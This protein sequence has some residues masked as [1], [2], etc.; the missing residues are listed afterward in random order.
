RLIEPPFAAAEPVAPNR[1]LF[2]F[3]T[4]LVAVSAGVAVA[5]GLN[6]VNP[7]FFTRRSLRGAIEFPVIGTV[8]MIMTPELARSRRVGAIMWIGSYA[9]LF[10]VAGAVIYFAEPGAAFVRNLLGGNAL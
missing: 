10:I 9:A 8:S 2:L 3:A 5:F 7:T 1:P 6:Q 4:L